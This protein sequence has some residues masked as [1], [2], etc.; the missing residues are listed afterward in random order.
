[1]GFEKTAKKKHS[2]RVNAKYRCI[3]DVAQKQSVYFRHADE[4]ALKIQK[5]GKNVLNTKV[6]FVRIDAYILLIYST[7]AVI[8]SFCEGQKGERGKF[9]NSGIR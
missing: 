9:V 5:N 1:M 8:R 6:Y 2:H 7:I 4:N 3:W